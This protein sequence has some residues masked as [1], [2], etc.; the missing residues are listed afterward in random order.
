MTSCGPFNRSWTATRSPPRHTPIVGQRNLFGFAFAF[1]F[2]L[3][4]ALK[5]PRNT[6]SQPLPR[7]KRVFPSSLLSPKCTSNISVSYRDDDSRIWPGNYREFIWL[8]EKLRRILPRNDSKRTERRKKTERPIATKGKKMVLKG[9]EIGYGE[10]VEKLDR[11]TRPNFQLFK[12]FSLTPRLFAARS[13]LPPSPTIREPG[14][15]CFKRRR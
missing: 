11:A 14:D 6:I 9:R 15:I 8:A 1:E 13:G 2:T 4:F 5:F 12:L 10:A 7:G 3:V